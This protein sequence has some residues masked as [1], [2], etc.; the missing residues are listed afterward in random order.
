MSKQDQNNLD[1]GK[2]NTIKRPDDESLKAIRDKTSNAKLKES[3][4]EKIKNA[5]KPI[6][7]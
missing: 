6:N 4:D 2:I 7:K 3:I 5:D 1:R